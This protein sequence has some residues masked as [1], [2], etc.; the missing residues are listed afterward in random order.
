MKVSFNW[1]RTNPNNGP[2]FFLSRLAKE[3]ESL[4]ISVVDDPQASDVYLVFIQDD[5]AKIATLKKHGIKVVQR[6]DGIYFDSK[7]MIKD[8]IRLNLPILNTYL[9]SDAVVFQSEFS[10]KLVTSHFGQPSN[11]RIIYNG[12]D[13]SHNIKQ[14]TADIIVCS[15]NWRRHK[16]LKEIIDVFNQL[17]DNWKLIVLGKPDVKISNSRITQLVAPSFESVAN[18]YSNASL[19]IHLSWLDFCPN[20]VVEALSVGLPVVCGNKGGTREL[21]EMTGGGFIATTDDDFNFDL[22]DLYHPP[23][24]KAIDEIVEFIE[25]KKYPSVNRIPISIQTCAAKYVD[26]FNSLCH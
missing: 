25:S 13:L 17:G 15:A 19:F 3:F 20:S 23:P 22:I 7:S 5:P 2:S 21:V 9:Q 6:L 4:G 8:I 11:S 26:L 1:P 12:I 18:I 16:R 10:K 24:I 14:N